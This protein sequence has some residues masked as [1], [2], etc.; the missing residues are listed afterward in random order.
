MRSLAAA[1]LACALT[2]LLKGRD[3]AEILSWIEGRPAALPFWMACQWL[4]LSPQA[5]RERLQKVAANP[6]PWRL[7]GHR[8]KGR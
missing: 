7:V 3:S 8:T 6:R 5:T 2:D 4:E 1:V